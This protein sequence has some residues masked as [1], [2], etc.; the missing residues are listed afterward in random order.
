MQR[1]VDIKKGR[2]EGQERWTV[3]EDRKKVGKFYIEPLQENKAEC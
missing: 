3:I 2:K 1:W